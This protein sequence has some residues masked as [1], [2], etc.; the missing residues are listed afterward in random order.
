MPARDT[1]LDDAL[2]EDPDHVSRLLGEFNDQLQTGA[3]PDIESFL[4]RCPEEDRRELLSLINTLVLADRAL[5]PLRKLLEDAPDEGW[6]P[7]PVST[8]KA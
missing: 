2:S 4:R 6:D 8:K 3:V 5:E 7:R 1:T